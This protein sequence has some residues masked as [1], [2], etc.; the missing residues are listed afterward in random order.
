MVFVS[1]GTVRSDLMGSSHCRRDFSGCEFG[2]L[3][4]T[5]E[6]NYFKDSV[7][8]IKKGAGQIRQRPIRR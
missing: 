8:C 2:V 3:F 1:S 5:P 6:E 7:R 4:A